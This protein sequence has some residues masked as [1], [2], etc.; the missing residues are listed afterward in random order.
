VTV[1]DGLHEGD[2]IVAAGVHTVYAGERVTAVTPLFAEAPE[3][4]P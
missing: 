3:S 2:R 1:D 4:A